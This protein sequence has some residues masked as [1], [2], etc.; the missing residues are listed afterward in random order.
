MANNVQH[1]RV[2]TWNKELTRQTNLEKYKYRI[3]YGY[4]FSV[5]YKANSFKQYSTEKGVK[6][7]DLAAKKQLI[8]KTQV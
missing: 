7:Y 1:L 8:D 6:S 4:T 3:E 5:F 2:H